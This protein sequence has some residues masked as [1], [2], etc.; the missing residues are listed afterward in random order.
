MAEQFPDNA[1]IQLDNTS[2][3][4]HDRLLPLMEAIEVLPWP[5]ERKPGRPTIWR[6]ATQGLLGGAV[7]LQTI[8]VGGKILTSPNMIKRF[9]ERCR[10]TR[11]ARATNPVKSN[12][13]RQLADQE[14]EQ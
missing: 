6:W 13:Y 10:N 9:L 1:A 5:A 8:H 3:D 2:E 4:P 11:T 12:T 14:G 7:R